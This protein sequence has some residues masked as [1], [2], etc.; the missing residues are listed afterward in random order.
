[1][2]QPFYKEN[3]EFDC[4]LFKDDEE[5]FALTFYKNGKHVNAVL[6]EMSKECR[7]DFYL[8]IK[9]KY[10]LI[11]NKFPLEI[12]NHPI[13]LELNSLLNNFCRKTGYNIAL[14]NETRYINEEFI[15]PE[16]RMTLDYIVLKELS[17]KH[18]ITK[19]GILVRRETK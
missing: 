13:Y 18:Y 1:M 9:E 6:S 15:L 8:H 10:D 3:K 4:K 2:Y 17:N 14:T 11:K 7:E 19:K 12:I 5:T 16:E